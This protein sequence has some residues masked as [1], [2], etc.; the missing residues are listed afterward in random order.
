[1]E[2]GVEGSRG[3]VVDGRRANNIE[4]KVWGVVLEVGREEELRTG[5]ERG[6]VR[7]SA[8]RDVD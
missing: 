6:G 5:G 7:E 4:G 8:L 3:L 2:V 1:M